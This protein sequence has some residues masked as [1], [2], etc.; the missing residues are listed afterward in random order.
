[1]ERYD[2]T[3][4]GAGPAGL[5][6]G[7]YC[8]RARLKT[9]ILESTIP[10]GTLRW[11]ER[12]E[13][14]PG[15]EEIGG[16]ELAERMEA[17]TRRFGAELRIEPV[18]EVL[19]QEDFKVIR[20]E[21]GEYE[22]G[23]VI[24]TAGG[25]PRKLGVPG[26]EEF[27]GRGVSYCALCDGPLF[28][29]RAVAVIGGGNSAVEEAL[30]LTKYASKVTVIHRGREFRAQE[31]LQEK[32]FQSPKIEVLWKAVVEEVQGEKLVEALLLKDIESGEEKRLKV[33][34]LFVFIGFVPSQVK[35]MHPKHD[36]GG[37]FLTDEWRATSCPGIFAAGDIRAQ[38][39]RQITTAVADGT[40][41]AV[42]AERYLEEHDLRLPA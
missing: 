25:E 9:L 23:A 6:A 19:W 16:A 8:G 10:G 33:S 4:I 32:L 24:I 12:V 27:T 22:A 36:R 1:M 26:E 41:A 2:V 31:I 39:V 11:T 35:G 18:A 13:D 28:R 17:Q 34:G 38:P 29:D 40:V 20:T 21:K 14:Y 15:I 3:I 30:F 42:A 7:L 5:T 37:F